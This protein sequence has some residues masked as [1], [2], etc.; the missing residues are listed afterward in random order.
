M[1]AGFSRVLVTPAKP[2]RMSGYDA[3]KDPFKGVHD[4][5]YAGAVVFDNGQM[6]TCLI[7]TDLIDFSHEY[8]DETKSKISQATGIPADHIFLTA[9]HNHDGPV[10]GSYENDLTADEKAYLSDLQT[11][12]VQAVNEAIGKLQP[13][14]IGVG[15][16]VS[17]MNINRRALQA[18]GTIWLGRN[19]DG[20]CDHEV[21]VIK[22]DDLSSHTI[23][24]LINWPCH[25]TTGG[26]DNYQVSGDW[27]GATERDLGKSFGGA[28]VMVSAGASGD[29]NP[30]FGP[31]NDF[32]DMENIGKILSDEVIRVAA[33]TKTFPVTD[34]A[35]INQVITAKGKKTSENHNPDVSLAPGKDVTIRVGAMK[36]GNIVLDGISGELMNEIGLDIK[37]DSPFTNTFV[38]S[39]CNGTSGYL[40]TDEAYKE[41]GY[42][43]MVSQTMPGTA[44][45]IREGFR[46][47]N[48]GL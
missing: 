11:G 37:K 9:V 19:P 35:V 29:I 38:L 15:K 24:L 22:I 8:V 10:T 32:G 46:K 6:R 42:E 3:R 33:E 48:N 47:I 39:H 34:L 13:V 45:L 27:P 7:T 41:G 40:C 17:K 25:A 36:I 23:G 44:G 31:G 1:K 14:K 4:D 21:G 26:Q 43:P 20:I 16:G 18:D 12:L 2:I 28:V 5:L 30:I